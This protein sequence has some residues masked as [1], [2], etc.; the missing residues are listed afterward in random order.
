[1]TGAFALGHGRAPVPGA[2]DD[3]AAHPALV[4]AHRSRS[5][6]GSVLPV[7]GK[8][9]RERTRPAFLSR[10]EAANLSLLGYQRTDTGV[11]ADQA[12]AGKFP[13]AWLVMA[14]AAENLGGIPLQTD[15]RALHANPQQPVRTDDFSDVLSVT[16]LR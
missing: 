9:P 5:R 15:W 6:A 7:P 13:S 3:V 12:A 4:F 1:M 16:V 8:Q 11:T 14:P 2:L 10:P